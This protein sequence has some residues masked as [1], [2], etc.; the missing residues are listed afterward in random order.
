M[1][2]SSRSV[3][4]W[5]RIRR[6]D[7]MAPPT[8]GEWTAWAVSVFFFA[9]AV[10]AGMVVY[11]TPPG[12]ATRD[13]LLVL[14]GAIFATTLSAFTFAIRS[15]ISARRDFVRL[16]GAYVSEHS[17]NVVRLRSDNQFFAEVTTNGR[18]LTLEVPLYKLGKSALMDLTKSR[19]IRGEELADRHAELLSVE[20]FNTL[21]DMASEWVTSLASVES[22]AEHLIHGAQSTCEAVEECRKR[23]IEMEQDIVEGSRG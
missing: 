17:G 15:E 4:L 6:P 3:P 20:Q 1:T 23:L 18:T 7:K 5:K 11:T 8:A 10:F 21:V 14:T 19:M 13:V 9:L 2:W 16:M 22:P 12:S